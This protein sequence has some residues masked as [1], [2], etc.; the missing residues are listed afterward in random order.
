MFQDINKEYT[1]L[2]CLLNPNYQQIAGALPEEIFT[3]KRIKLFKAMRNL[4]TEGRTVTLPAIELEME[5]PLQGELLAARSTDPEPLIKDLSRIAKRRYLKK[6][7]AELD[8]YADEVYTPDD[9]EIERI[10]T[11]PNLTLERSNNSQ[12]DALEIVD[13]IIEKRDD[14]YQNLVTGINFIDKGFNGGLKRGTI[15]VIAATGGAGKT[16]LVQNITQNLAKKGIH[17]LFLS[18][19]MSRKDLMQRYASSELE[20]SYSRIQEGKTITDSELAQ[21]AEYVSDFNESGIYII[22]DNKLTV[23]NIAYEIRRHVREHNVQAVFIDHLQLINHGGL[24]AAEL[25][26]WYGVAVWKLRMLAKELKIAI[27]L[28]SQ[29]TNKNGETVV[30]GSG[31]VKPTVDAQINA[32]AGDKIE[33]TDI[34]VIDVYF[35]KNRYGPVSKGKLYLDGSIQKY[36]NERPDFDNEAYAGLYD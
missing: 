23:H 12:I 30:R 18:L 20:L 32:I 33:G 29:V 3:G 17:S 27:V 16:T 9:I 31:D 26:S 21:I 24:S 36:F 11:L 35:E 8:K 25:N 1:L 13:E 10:V 2:A 19:E 4:I 7:A 28:L 22:E 34:S 15:A 5:E 14:S 6:M